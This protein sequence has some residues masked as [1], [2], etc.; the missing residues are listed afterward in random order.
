L[1]QRNAGFLFAANDLDALLDDLFIFVAPAF[2]VIGARRFREL[3]VDL[4]FV[5]RLGLFGD[6][7]DKSQNFLVGDQCALGA[8]ELR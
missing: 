4:E 5:T 8:D 2:L 6:E 7:L 3:L 1:E